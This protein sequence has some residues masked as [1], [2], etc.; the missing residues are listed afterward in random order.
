MNSTSLVSKTKKTLANP[1]PRP[2]PKPYPRE[3]SNPKLK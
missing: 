1:N 2:Y 3:G